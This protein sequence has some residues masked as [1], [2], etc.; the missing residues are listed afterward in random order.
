M[1]YD[2]WYKENLYL[3]GEWDSIALGYD[4]QDSHMKDSG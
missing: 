1:V 4:P 3:S 2:L